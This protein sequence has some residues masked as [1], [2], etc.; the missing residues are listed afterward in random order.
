MSFH[1][2][3][4][5]KRKMEPLCFDITLNYDIALEDNSQLTIEFIKFLCVQK[6]Q[7]PEPCPQQQKLLNLAQVDLDQ[8]CKVLKV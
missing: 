4:M 8:D 5:F 7:I 3:C 1:S 2:R 6:G